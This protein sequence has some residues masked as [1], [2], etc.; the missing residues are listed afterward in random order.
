MRNLYLLEMISKPSQNSRTFT[1]EMIAQFLQL[2]RSTS[3]SPNSLLK[4]PGCHKWDFNRLSIPDTKTG[5]K[6][7]RKAKI[8]KSVSAN[9]RAF[10]TWVLTWPCFQHSLKIFQLL[11]LLGSCRQR[12]RPS[13]SQE[14]D[15]CGSKTLRPIT[16]SLRPPNVPSSLPSDT[17]VRRPSAFLVSTTEAMMWSRKLGRLL[18]SLS[19]W[20]VKERVWAYRSD[21]F[22]DG[23]YTSTILLHRCRVYIRLLWWTRRGMVPRSLRGPEGVCLVQNSVSPANWT[24]QV[25][26][27][28]YW[29]PVVSY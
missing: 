5:L 16:P 9:V 8:Q 13:Q 1:S 7:N 6:R 11:L 22:L 26:T 27:G 21:V 2:T 20:R 29:S 18:L 12:S 19:F 10:P 17:P 3:W 4:A 25:L 23:F 24:P 15:V 28:P 14:C